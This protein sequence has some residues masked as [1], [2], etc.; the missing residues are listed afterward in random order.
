MCDRGG[1]L[2]STLD[3]PAILVILA[4]LHGDLRTV[5]I[6]HAL[7]RRGPVLII[8]ETQQAALV[9]LAVECYVDEL[10]RHARGFAPALC[11]TLDDE[12]LRAAVRDD[13]RRAGA[14]GFVQRGPVRLHLEMT[15]LFGVGFADDPQYPWA[16]ALQGSLGF[17]DPMDR[18]DDL[19]A[20]VV[21]YVDEVGGPD[22]A[23]GRAAWRRLAARV[24]GGLELDPNDLDAELLELLTTVHPHKV[25]AVGA[26]PVQ[27]LISEART[28]AREV[29]G[30]TSARAHALMA[31][32]A[33]GLGHRCDTDPFLP[34]ISRALVP[35]D[36]TPERVAERL[37]QRARTWL[38]ATLRASG[39]AP[40]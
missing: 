32:L 18:A 16:A 14:L 27:R 8:G 40:A 10:T 36:A 29:H 22:D 2:A 25:A 28:R 31:A 23:H 38:A 1:G 39:A 26:A 19:H 9:G 15:L 6:M 13:M 33:F 7:A 20:R 37:E 12:P 35:G 24:D 21:A 3:D 5:A 30:F 11:D 34:W 4:A 17:A